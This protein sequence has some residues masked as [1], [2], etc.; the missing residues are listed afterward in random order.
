MTEK[1]N[2]LGAEASVSLTTSGHGTCKGPEVHRTFLLTHKGTG[3]EQT[4]YL[5][6]GYEMGSCGTIRAW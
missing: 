4:I 5:L 3:C 6:C 2:T 1:E